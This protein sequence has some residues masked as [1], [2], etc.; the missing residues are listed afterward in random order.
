MRIQNIFFSGLNPVMRALLKSRF[1]RV[2]SRSISLLCYRGIKT[3]YEYETPLSYV[4]CGESILFLSNYETR[5]WRNFTTEPYSV[6]VLVERKI[7]FGQ[8]RL[9]SG[10]SDFLTSNVAYFISQL[11]RDAPI[12]GIKLESDGS[13]TAASMERIEDRVVLVAVELGAQSNS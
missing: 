5:W 1:H 2:A 10:E 12:Y 7:L 11:P 3:G 9:Y 8:A 6:K 4:R 13:P